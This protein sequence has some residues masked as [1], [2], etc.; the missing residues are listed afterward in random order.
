M[1]LGKSYMGVL[2][3]VRTADGYWSQDYVGQEM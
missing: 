3:T 2:G 1:G